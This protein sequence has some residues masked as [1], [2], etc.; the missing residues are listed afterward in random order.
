[1]AMGSINQQS[2]FLGMTYSIHGGLS[3][4]ASGLPF[5]GVDAGGYGGFGDEETYIRWTEYACFCPL[6]RYHGPAPPSSSGGVSSSAFFRLTCAYCTIN[7][8]E[9]VMTAVMLTGDKE[10]I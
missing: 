1:M 6:M 2:N 10:K 5:W 3:A 4:A 8:T 9:R 7:T